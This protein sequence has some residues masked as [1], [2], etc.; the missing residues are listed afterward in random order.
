MLSHV[1]TIFRQSRILT[2]AQTSLKRAVSG[3]HYAL[4]TAQAFRGRL[5]QLV[6]APALQA[7]G[8]RFE[9]CTAHHSS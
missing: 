6:R 9:S 4:Q 5:A 3:A 2:G 7:G 1:G 8:R